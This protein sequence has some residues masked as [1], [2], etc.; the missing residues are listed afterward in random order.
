MISNSYPQIAFCL[1]ITPA[2]ENYYSSLKKMDITTVSTCLY[3][4]KLGRQKHVTGHVNAARNLGMTIHANRI[5]DL[6]D[7]I[8]DCLEFTIRF[9][10]L[11]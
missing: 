7:P 4:S 11:G 6:H 3:I 1:A 9:L 2:Q 10:E 8:N 5:T